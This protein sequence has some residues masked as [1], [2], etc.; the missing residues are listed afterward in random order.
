MRFEVKYSKLSYH[1]FYLKNL[2]MKWRSCHREYNEAWLKIITE[3][4]DYERKLIDKFWQILSDQA[5]YKKT[6]D[7]IFNYEKLPEHYEIREIFQGTEKNFLKLWKALSKDFDIA[8]K[9]LEANIIEHSDEIHQALEIL[10]KFYASK[11]NANQTGIYLMVLPETVASGGGK[12]ISPNNVL[13]EGN[14]E[15]F[16]S[17]KIINILIHEMI[18]LYLE[19]NLK[20]KI[21][22]E[23]SNQINYDEFKEIISSLFVPEG[24]LT[25]EFF[26]VKKEFAGEEIKMLNMVEQYIK[27]GKQIDEHF[28][29]KVLDHKRA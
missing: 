3:F 12:F 22:P 7:Y 5:I 18:H 16:K 26:G 19:D 14:K 1:F 20:V 2:T 24:Y 10:E 25:K 8:K 23:F 9:N 17:I 4:S 21:Y 6:R 13:L 28:V 11:I 15:R 29:K 27:S